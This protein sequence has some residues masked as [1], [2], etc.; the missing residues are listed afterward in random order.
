MMLWLKLVVRCNRAKRPPKYKSPCELGSWKRSTWIIDILLAGC[1]SFLA[2]FA[3]YSLQHLPRA[4]PFPDPGS[5]FSPP[6]QSYIP[7]TQNTAAPL[8]IATT[9]Y[10]RICTLPQYIPMSST[11][12][13]TNTLSNLMHRDLRP[14]TG[15]NHPRNYSGVDRVAQGR[16]L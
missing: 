5:H 13:P 4:L 11:K 12:H 1:P 8:S 15:A 7:T 2:S 6:S 10:P 3:S 9:P 16:T 14:L